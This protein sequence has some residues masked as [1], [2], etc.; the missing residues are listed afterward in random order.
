MTLPV[1]AFLLFVTNQ[2]PQ[3]PPADVQARGRALVDALTAQRFAEVERELT[4]QMKVTFSVERMAARWATLVAQAGAF[5]SCALESRLVAIADKKMVITACRFERGTI[6]IQFAFDAAGKVSGFSSRPVAPASTAPASTAYTPPSYATAGSYSEQDVTVGGAEWP[7][8]ATLTVP[9]G[10]GPFPA[11]VLVHGSGPGDRDTTIGPN[12]PFKDLALGLAARGIAVLRY[13]KRSRV[14]GR[15]MAALPSMTVKDEVIDDV[16]EALEVLRAQ[17]KIDGSRLFVIGHSLGGM[18]VPRIVAANPSLAGAIVM[19]GAARPI[20]DAIVR[21]ARYLAA[22]DGAVTSDEQ[23]G[24]D[25]AARMASEIKALTSA[26]AA[27][28]RLVLNAPPSYWLDLRGYD[29]PAAAAAQKVPLLVLQ[30][31]RDYQV[32]MEEFAAWQGAL[33]ARRDVTSKSYPALNH[34][35]LPGA[36]KSLP[37]EYDTASHVDE[38]VIV[39]IARWIL[40]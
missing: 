11:V 37:P 15:R 8:P 33:A 25:A 28:G 2:A 3:S 31:E 32:T 5:R 39:D 27:A 6:D 14:H 22:A 20:E 40:R 26:D 1:I 21:Q 24:I 23:A 18:L 34:L 30:G 35:F 12:K 10:A 4:D 29:P 16:A 7:L 9:A 38:Q 19:A 13:D 17:S 36:G